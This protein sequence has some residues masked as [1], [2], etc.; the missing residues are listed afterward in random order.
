M[1]LKPIQRTKIDPQADSLFY[2]FPRFVNH[3]DKK[4]ITQ[5]TN[6]YRKKLSSN[7][8]V[9]DLMSSW[10][11][12][13]PDEVE[14]A[15]VE[16]HGMN[17][18]ELARNPRLD[19]YFVQDLT[20]HPILPLGDN[21]V[22]AIVC[23]VSVQ[24]LEYPEV[25]FAEVYRILK[26]QGLAIFSFSNRMFYQKAI[27]AWR[28]TSELGRVKLVTNYFQSVTGFS[29]PENVISRSNILNFFNILGM[30]FS[31]PFY[32]VFAYKVRTSKQNFF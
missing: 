9:L 31:D 19:H 12:H 32:A 2:A 23:A 17:Q 27:A 28:N 13:L 16:G 18:E 30:G 10:V 15:H 8:R 3:V 26:P 24:Y 14:F 20:T 22:D 25:I 4:F 11:S 1:L 29:Q 21:D 5:L 6:F 7:T